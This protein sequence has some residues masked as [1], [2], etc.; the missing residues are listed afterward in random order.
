[1]P[2]KILD[3]FRLAARR[4]A[5]KSTQDDPADT[6]YDASHYFIDD[7]ADPWKEHGE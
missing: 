7:V 5:R 6:A 3:R 4:A 2:S 1:M